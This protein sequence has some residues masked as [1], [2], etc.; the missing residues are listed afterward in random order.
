MGCRQKLSVNV[1]TVR[2][3]LPVTPLKKKRMVLCKQTHCFVERLHVERFLLR[4]GNLLIY[5]ATPYVSWRN[6]NADTLIYGR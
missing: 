1:R 6:G 3:A 2:G 5:V 4:C